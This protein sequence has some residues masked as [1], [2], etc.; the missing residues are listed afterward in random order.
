MVMIDS[1]YPHARRDESITTIP[2]S[3]AFSSYTKPEVRTLVERSMS[4]T[5]DMIKRWQLPVWDEIDSSIETAEGEL[6]TDPHNRN[7]GEDPHPLPC[8]Q[9]TRMRPPPAILL[10]AKEYVHP[11]GPDSTS[12]I[13]DIDRSRHKRFLGWED[14]SYKFIRTVLDVEG[15]HYSIFEGKNVIRQPLHIA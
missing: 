15:H 11:R 7:S 9:Q 3:L 12:V 5:G 10:R 13:C 6:A 2:F 4:Q 14:Y 8:P 1:V